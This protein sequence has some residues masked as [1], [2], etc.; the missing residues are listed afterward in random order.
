MKNE[1]ISTVKQFL[2]EASIQSITKDFVNL[3]LGQ[4]SFTDYVDSI[5][6]QEHIIELLR[7]GIENVPLHEFA[8]DTVVKLIDHIKTHNIKDKPMT[9]TSDKTAI[10]IYTQLIRNVLNSINKLKDL[11]EDELL[12]AKKIIAL[13]IV[14]GD[15]VSSNKDLSKLLVIPS[16][17]L[18]KNLEVDENGFDNYNKLIVS[19][20]KNIN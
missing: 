18:A 14:V 15:F 17:E 1:Y 5:L 11:P 9:A 10:Q 6:T 13:M 12:N 19:H 20:F 2:V 3:Q 4:M 7:N 8:D 16:G